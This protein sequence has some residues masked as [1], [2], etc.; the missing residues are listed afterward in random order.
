[1]KRA[2]CH[3]SLE[4]LARALFHGSVEVISAEPSGP[5]SAYVTLTIEGGDLPEI[6]ADAPLPT[7]QCIIS[8]TAP[9]IPPRFTFRIIDDD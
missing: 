9:P 6:P 7:A 3:I 5:F 4:L 8:L 2:R 1:V